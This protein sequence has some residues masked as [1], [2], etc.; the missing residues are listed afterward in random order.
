MASRRILVQLQRNGGKLFKTNLLNNTCNQGIRKNTITQKFGSI[1]PI[2]NVNCRSFTTEAQTEE[3]ENVHVIS[4]TESVTGESVRHEFQ[5]ETRQLLDIVARS[6]YSEKEV[7]IREI[8]SNSSDALEKL[9]QVQVTGQ[10]ISDS[11]S[12]LE[13]HLT[14]DEEKGLFIIQDFG[15][16][17]SKDELINNL[18]TIAR[19]GSKAFIEKAKHES[20]D[21]QNIIG[22]FG[23]GFYSTF[24]VGDKIDVFTKSYEPSA[25]GYHWSSDGSGSY[26]IAEAEGVTRGTKVIIHLKSDDRRFSLKTTVEDIIRCYSNFVGFPI[27]LN[28]SRLNNIDALWTSSE[29]DVSETDHSQFYQF[30]S[31]TSDEPRYS[32]M[33]K[34]D[35]PL[36][37]R[38][39]LYVPSNIPEMF[40]FGRMEL[41]VSLYSRKILIQSKAQKILPEW[42]RFIRGVVDSEDIPLNLS[43]ELL[44]DSALIQKLSDVLVTKLLRYFLEQSRKDEEKFTKFM[45]ECGNYFREGVVTDQSPS[46]REDIAKLLRFESSKER[47]GNLKSLMDYISGMKEDQKEIFFLSAP[48]RELAESSPYYEALKAKDVEVLFTYEEND[49]VVFAALKEFQKKNIISAENYLMGS[50]PLTDDV[51]TDQPDIEKL[52]ETETNELMDWI[53]NTLGK[54]KCQNIKES[55]RLA[56]HP[57]MITV[58]DMGAARR[59]LKFVKSGPNTDLLKMK[60]EVL[61]PTFEINPNHEIVRSLNTLKGSNPMLAEL[62]VN[63]LFD[64]ALIT[65]GLLDDPREMVGRLNTLL[66]KVMTRLNIEEQKKDKQQTIITP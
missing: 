11:D 63:Q 8:V 48:S 35:A 9:R 65:A 56:S 13:I 2:Y 55:K 15:I 20:I 60:F 34:A 51:I 64:N 14:T 54:T 16:G 46:R 7:F 33:Y 26:E 27:Y 39:V 10:Q 22:Q 47:P 4:D 45:K 38:S 53:Q 17:M 42:L 57:A 36:N 40:G 25:S 37:I 52:S 62:L 30:I 49:E 31:N 5:A 61:Q 44:Q 58:P 21:A 28:G 24:M 32:L 66:S 19:S 23:V 1:V 29:R 12:P 50:D 41:G 6:L 59:W 3:V 18:G 43:R